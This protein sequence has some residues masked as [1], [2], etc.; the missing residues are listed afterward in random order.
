ME[1]VIFK[2]EYVFMQ[3]GTFT[4]NKTKDKTRTNLFEPDIYMLQCDTNIYY[5]YT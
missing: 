4:I 3:I 1:N 2:E 5:T